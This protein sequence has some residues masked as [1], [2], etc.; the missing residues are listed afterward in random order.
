MAEFQFSTP[1]IIGGCVV[2]LPGAAKPLHD[3]TRMKVMK[4]IETTA[5][6]GNAA[7]Q[8][9]RASKSDYP[10]LKGPIRTKP[11]LFADNLPLEGRALPHR[12]VPPQSDDGGSLSGDGSASPTLPSGA[13]SYYQ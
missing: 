10:W 8:A 12:L 4:L 3:E 9:W 6:R 2:P 1:Y 13:G 5:N 11:D 7:V